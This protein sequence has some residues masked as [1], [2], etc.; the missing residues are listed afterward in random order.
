MKGSKVFKNYLFNAG[1]QLLAIIVPL[2][3]TPYISRVLNADGIGIYSFTFSIVSY[4]TLC[5]ALGT[6]SYANK[7]IGILQDDPVLRTQK[8]FDVF[9]LRLITTSAALVIYLCYAL[10]FAEH[11][12]IALIQS[13]YIL[14]V[15]FDTSWFFQGMEDF[16]R[17]ALR[18]YFFKFLNVAFIFIFVKDKDDLWKYVFGLALLTFIGN[19]SLIPSLRKYLVRIK[20][21]KIKP[22]CDFKVIVQLF[23]PALAV[24]IYAMLDKSMIGWITHD[25]AQNGYYEQSEKIIKMCL[26]LI[27]ALITVT[28]PRISKLF[29]EGNKKEAEATLYKSAGFVWFFGVPLTLGV[30][31]IAKTLVPVFFG[32]GWEPVINML[33][34]MSL[35]FITMG[36]NQTMGTLYF[37][38][39]GKQ[40]IYTAAI[41]TGGIFNI[42]FNA[43]LIPH[44]GALGAGA[45]SVLGEIV[46]FM[47]ESVYIAKHKSFSLRPV[48]KASIKYLIAGAIMLAALIFAGLNLPKN[49]AV[50]AGMIIAGA[51]IYFA[52]LLIMKDKF[53]FEIAE[54][55]KAKFHIGKRG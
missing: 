9:S 48:F 43:I 41:I 25:N 11:K 21:Y 30:I 32:N 47:F 33:Y 44:L 16:K 53:I 10:F 51:A 55:V 6:V 14:G 26:M 17:I 28:M 24:Q 46:I 15:M 19:A 42:I 5:S 18:N 45:A 31:G 27:T 3:T 39:T 34:V 38:A 52:A 8:F 2:V 12:T 49:A 37:I 23:I 35:L 36:L 22:F 7:Q 20:G 1:Y 29:A 54:I 50:L 40:N 13:F 4:F